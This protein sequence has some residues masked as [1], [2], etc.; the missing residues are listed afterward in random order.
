MHPYQAIRHLKPESFHT[1]IV[2]A[3]ILSLIVGDDSSRAETDRLIREALLVA[4]LSARL[5]RLHGFGAENAP[6]AFLAGL[7]HNTG[8]MVLAA[9]KPE[10][11]RQFI[12]Q[13]KMVPKDVRVDFERRLW[14]A[15]F[16]EIGGHLLAEWG[17]P[18]ALIEAVTYQEEPGL[19]DHPQSPVLTTLHVAKWLAGWN[20]TGRTIGDLTIEENGEARL[21]RAFLNRQN[22]RVQPEIYRQYLQELQEEQPS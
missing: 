6:I 20:A 9:N 13:L 19:R 15:S 14:G 18:D 8:P 17:L 2:A 1:T 3:T 22:F 10:K 21:D 7:L 4:K 16:G 12:E 11:M 5:C